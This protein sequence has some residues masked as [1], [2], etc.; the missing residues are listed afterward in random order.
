MCGSVSAAACNLMPL[1]QWQPQVFP[2]IG[3]GLSAVWSD[4]W[5]LLIM[6][7]LVT[8]SAQTSARTAPVWT[9]A[10]SASWTQSPATHPQHT[11]SVKQ[12]SQYL[13]IR[14]CHSSRTAATVRLQLTHNQTRAV[15][16]LQDV[17]AVLAHREA[18]T[19]TP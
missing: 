8:S 7:V 17:L 5:Q 14:V 9:L 13:D 15:L 1:R 16:P 12:C 6:L 11:Q 19:D 2:L 10:R 18:D 3:A 4:G